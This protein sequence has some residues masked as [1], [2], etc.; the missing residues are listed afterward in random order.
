MSGESASYI[1]W[2]TCPGSCTNILR[3][4]KRRGRRMRMEMERARGRY[5]GQEGEHEDEKGQDDKTE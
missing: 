2:R 1:R 3:R 4:G 5:E